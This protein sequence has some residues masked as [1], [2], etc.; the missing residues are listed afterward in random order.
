S[1]G[2]SPSYRD[3]L[4]RFRAQLQDWRAAS[5]R[6]SG[7]PNCGREL[8]YSQSSQPSASGYA[9]P[10]GY[11]Q[12]SAAQTNLSRAQDVSV[13]ELY[14]DLRGAVCRNDWDGAVQLTNALIGS[15]VSPSYRQQL[16]GFR[17]QLQDWRAVGATLTN[18]PD[19]TGRIAQAQ[20]DPER[21]EAVN[22][23]APL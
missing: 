9:Q 7:T 2:I 5:S 19:C 23:A 6:F 21:L 17:S 12:A 20:A 8:T 15:P 16:V 4:T 1:P 10:S 14:A 22:W 18:M 11:A 13:Q 3:E